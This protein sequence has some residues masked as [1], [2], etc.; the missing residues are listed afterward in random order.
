MPIPQLGKQ[1]LRLWPEQGGTASE[2]RLRASLRPEPMWTEPL[3]SVACGQ[4]AATVSAGQNPA[5]AWCVQRLGL[6]LGLT[7]LPGSRGWKE[8]RL[9]AGCWDWPSPGQAGWN[10]LIGYGPLITRP[11]HAVSQDF[12]TGSGQSPLGGC[13]SPESLPTAGH[14]PTPT[15]A[16]EE[17]HACPH[18]L[19]FWGAQL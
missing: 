11:V 19:G 17:L 13:P 4:G 16:P 2:M 9:P 8:G 5:H 6:T 14:A 7:R 18:W 10:C 12:P 3:R 1:S 15:P